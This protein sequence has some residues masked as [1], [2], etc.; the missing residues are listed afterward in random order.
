M[1][2]RTSQV[3]TRKQR[4]PRTAGSGA[5][6]KKI[7]ITVDEQVLSQTLRDARRENRTLSAH[8]TAALAREVRRRKLQEFFEQYEKEE[9]SF[10]AQE[11]E[12]ARRE[13][14]G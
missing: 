11:L 6:A 3:A 1:P 13:W 7:S 10:T 8:I 2:R 12:A 14:L 9:G 5:R 4:T